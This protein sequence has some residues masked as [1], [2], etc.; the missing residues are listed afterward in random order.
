MKLKLC[1][2]GTKMN[3]TKQHV[4]KHCFTCKTTT[5]PSGSIGMGVWPH[6]MLHMRCV[7][8]YMCIIIIR[9]CMYENGM[10]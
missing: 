2:C 9:T 3:T 7:H 8:V 1:M 6:A 4:C 10:T 5:P